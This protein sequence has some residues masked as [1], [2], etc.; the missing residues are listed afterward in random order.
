MDDPNLDEREHRLALAGLRRVNRLCQTG[1]HV[2]NQ[3]LQIANRRSLRKLEILDLGCGSGDVAMTVASR[4]QSR[5]ECRVTGWDMSSVAIEQARE[6]SQK[7]GDHFGSAVQFDVAN[8]FEIPSK[9][10]DKPIFD[11]VYCSLFLHHFGDDQSAEILSIMKRLSRLAI[12]VD[13]LCRSRLG[14]I[15]AKIGCKLLSR[16][17]VVQFDGPQSVRAAYT[18]SEILALANRVGLTPNRLHR[19]WPERFLLIW[20]AP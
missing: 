8:V 13:D 3:I 9:L 12:I 5:L 18:E 10:A 17:R 16:S 15:L 14:W 19:H 1:K 7:S 11:V 2:S 20:E 6:Q 4:L